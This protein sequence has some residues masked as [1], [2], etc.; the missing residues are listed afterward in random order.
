MNRSTLE[1]TIVSEAQLRS[2]GW[3]MGQI[4]GAYHTG[5][6]ILIDDYGQPHYFRVQMAVSNEY[7]VITNIEGPQFTNYTDASIGSEYFCIAAFPSIWV[8][9][10]EVNDDDSWNNKLLIKQLIVL[11]GKN[12]KNPTIKNV[13]IRGNF[14]A[15]YYQ[16]QSI[17]GK[18]KI[19]YWNLHKPRRI[20]F[21]YRSSEVSREFRELVLSQDNRN[22]ALC[23]TGCADL[24]LKDDRGKFDLQAEIPR[25]KQ[26]PYGY[27]PND[28][29]IHLHIDSNCCYIALGIY[30]D[31]KQVQK[32]GLRTPR[33][34]IRSVFSSQVRR[35]RL[36]NVDD[37]LGKFRD[38]SV[39]GKVIICIFEF[40]IYR[41]MVPDADGLNKALADKSSSRRIIIDYGVNGHVLA[42]YNEVQQCRRRSKVNCVAGNRATY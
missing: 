40:G 37:H 18:H 13:I 10:R 5:L 4:S 6:L 35:I 19:F 3:P 17:G 30:E 27:S 7:D 28:Q 22:V 21:P 32:E 14:V 24:F 42:Q 16:G 38:F 36:T 41:I 26:F 34:E 12:D 15:A 20:L 33:I 31:I 9:R 23:A 8:Y 39:D 29:D 25:T 1:T 11:Y 2:C